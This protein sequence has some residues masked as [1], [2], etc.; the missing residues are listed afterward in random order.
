MLTIVSEKNNLCR[1]NNSQFDK[2]NRIGW[3]LATLNGRILSLD[4]N[5]ILT[6]ENHG[7][8]AMWISM[9]D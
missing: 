1:K 7:S 8:I 9:Q 4:V 2:A 3:Q 6:T 5:V